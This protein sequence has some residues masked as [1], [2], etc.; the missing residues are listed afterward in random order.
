MRCPQCQ[1]ENPEGLTFC[2]ACG[3]PLSGHCTACGFTKQSG[4]KFCG[5]CGTS[6]TAY[7]LAT[8]PSQQ[9]QRETEAEYATTG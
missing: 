5:A 2:N 8:N 3:I 1:D 7:V 4:S 6:L 9:T